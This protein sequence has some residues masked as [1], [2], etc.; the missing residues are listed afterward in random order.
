MYIFFEI[1]TRSGISY[2]SYISYN[3]KQELK[4]MIYLDVNN[5]YG[6]A[7]SKFLSASELK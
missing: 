1:G 2:I 4:Q 5:I 3:Q 7:M 6:Y